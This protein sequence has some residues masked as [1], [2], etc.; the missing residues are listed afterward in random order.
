[1]TMHKTYKTLQE[2]PPR[3]YEGYI[4]FSDKT[5]PEIVNGSLPQK[6]DKGF[7]VE[8][9]LYNADNKI[10]IMI[11][12]TGDLHIDEFDLTNLPENSDLKEEKYYAHRIDNSK[13]MKFKQLWQLEKDSV[14]LG[15]DYFSMKALLFVGFEK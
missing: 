5:K 3:N 4:W 7:L 2:I 14:N 1:M 13:K 10:S 8:G 9:M 12:H 11:R 15:W 6:P